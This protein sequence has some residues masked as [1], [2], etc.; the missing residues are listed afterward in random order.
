MI[1]SV[2]LEVFLL[3]YQLD[4]HLPGSSHY[5]NDNMFTLF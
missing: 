2:C 4:V 1:Y 5:R 3:K